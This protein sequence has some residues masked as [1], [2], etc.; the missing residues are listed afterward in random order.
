MSNNA[1]IGSIVGYQPDAIRPWV[2]SIEMNVPDVQKFMVVYEGTPSETIQFLK[3][4]GFTVLEK[5]GPFPIVTQ[6]FFDYYQLLVSNPDLEL[7]IMTDVK[8][9]IFQSDPFQ[10]VGKCDLLVGEES[11][12]IDD[13]PWAK[14][15]YSATFP[16]EYEQIKERTS[17]CAGVFGGTRE[18][19]ADLCQATFRQSIGSLALH[20]DH[21][22]PPDQ[23]AL[24]IVLGSSLLASGFEEGSLWRT[25]HESA[26]VTHLGV[27]LDEGHQQWVND[28]IPTVDE[29]GVVR[30]EDG[31]EFCIVHQYDRFP[32]LNRKVLEKYG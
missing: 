11:I 10:H 5:Q 8:D 20:R 26:W 30:N 23:A 3:I 12:K 32:D 7:V 27:C 25:Q 29:D 14:I 31:R 17:L 22:Q 28:T 6:R 21:G 1:I 13:M 9:V 16:F 24:N 15:N 18:A 2:N 19:V 4:R